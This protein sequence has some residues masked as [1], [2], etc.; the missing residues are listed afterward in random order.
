MIPGSLE[1]GAGALR[2]IAEGVWHWLAL[3]LPAAGHLPL[4]RAL[5][6]GR[7]RKAC[8]PLAH[9]PPRPPG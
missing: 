1:D 9:R 6:G 5:N 3:H 4:A 2:H 7:R 8:H